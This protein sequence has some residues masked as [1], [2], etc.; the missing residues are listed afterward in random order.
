VRQ[1]RGEGRK[2]RTREGAGRVGR[3]TST[4]DEQRGGARLVVQLTV[5]V[6]RLE[7]LL[8][9]CGGRRSHRQQPEEGNRSAGEQDEEGRERAYREGV[10]SST[11][12]YTSSMVQ[13]VKQG[14]WG[15]GARRGS[16]EVRLFI[17]FPLHLV[18]SSTYEQS[19]CLEF[20]S[21]PLE[22][23]APCPPPS[24]P[25]RFLPPTSSPEGT[26]TRSSA[27]FRQSAT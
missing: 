10:V 11:H 3:L 5:A 27:P 2:R 12:C 25:T 26:T 22:T 7:L 16:F 1:E 21:A 14:E 19:Y 20:I 17:L 23:L 15:E 13:S 4:L 8:T 9:L 18:H 24:P 6:T